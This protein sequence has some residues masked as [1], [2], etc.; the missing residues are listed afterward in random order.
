MTLKGQNA[1][2][3]RKHASAGAQ[4]TNLKAETIAL[5][6]SKHNDLL[7]I[8]IPPTRVHK[9]WKNVRRYTLDW[10]TSVRKQMSG[11]RV[12]CTLLRRRCSP[13]VTLSTDPRYLPSVTE[14]IVLSSPMPPKRRISVPSAWRFVFNSVITLTL[15]ILFYNKWIQ[16]V[17]IY[18]NT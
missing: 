9:M 8:V 10:G 11:R 16:T 4:C 6:K 7:I 15:N 5:T 1:L 17:I 18:D 12:S 14:H 2:C 13:T 3:R